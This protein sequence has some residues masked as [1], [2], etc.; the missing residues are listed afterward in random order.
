MANNGQ[1]FAG[2]SANSPS[3]NLTLSIAMLVG[4]F[5]LG[6]AALALAGLLAAQPRRQPTLGT[7]PTDT[8]LFGAVIVGTLIIVG[9]ISFFP[10]LALG[11]LAEGLR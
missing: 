1:N 3:Y 9:A 7:L 6:A 8:P 2:L 11:P 10:A 5:G 4:R